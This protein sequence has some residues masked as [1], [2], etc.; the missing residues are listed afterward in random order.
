MKDVYFFKKKKDI[1]L[2]NYFNNYKNQR[3][4]LSDIRILKDAS[5]NHLT[6]FDN[7]RYK[8]EAENTKA[9]FCI[10]TSKLKNYLPK[11]CEVIITEKVLYDVASILKDIYPDADIDYP[12]LNLKLSNK[13]KFSGVKFGNNVFIGKNLKKGK[14]LSL[15][16]IQLLKVMSL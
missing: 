12:D 13:R 1:I 6:F 5:Q 10:T 11:T 8:D 7:I 14:T 4:K 3:I 16:I 2:G 9:K 15:E